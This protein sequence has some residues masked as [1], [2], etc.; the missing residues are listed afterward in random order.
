MSAPAWTGRLHGGVDG[1]AGLLEA[2]RQ[3]AAGR[4]VPDDTQRDLVVALEELVTN[5]LRHGAAGGHVPD[6]D[7]SLDIRDGVLVLVVADD[8]RAFDPLGVSPPARDRP[9]EDRP[10]GGLGIH[11]VQFARARQ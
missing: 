1:I 2:C 10:I 6:V 7:V 8:G 5:V 11:L 9:L 3:V 4:G